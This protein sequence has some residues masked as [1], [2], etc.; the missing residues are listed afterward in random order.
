[1]VGRE[2]GRGERGES[3]VEDGIRVGGGDR[4]SWWDRAWEVSGSWL[5][6]VV[7]EGGDIRERKW[8][9]LRGVSGSARYLGGKLEGWSTVEGVSG[10][11]QVGA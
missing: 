2:C 5:M 3:R 1:M 11:S 10:G 7:K 9:R 8:E 4:E 6:V